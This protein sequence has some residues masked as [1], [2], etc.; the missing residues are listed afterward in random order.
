MKVLTRLKPAPAPA[1][2]CSVCGFETARDALRAALWVCPACGVHLAM[3]AH[4]RVAS[5]VDPRSFRE[6]DRRMIS[7]DPLRFADLHAYRARL[8]DARKRT[9]LREA[10]VVGQARVGGLPVV[11]AVFEF[12][13]LGGSM[14]SVVGEKIADAFEVATRR[15]WPVI[16]V[17]SS[18][19]AR[20][21]EGM[22]SLMQMAKTAA[23]RARHHAAG[24]AYISVLA[25]PTFGGVA[26]SFASLGD[27][28]IA[29]PG[30]R[31]G[32]AGPR[33]IEATVG[34][35]LPADSH[36]A[37]R[38]FEGGMV[39]LLLE[40]RA[41]RETVQFL[42]R[43]LGRP[44]GRPWV[45]PAL[46][47]RLQ[48]DTSPAAW[49][50]VQ[51]ARHPRRPRSSDYIGR[52]VSSFVELHG[53]RQ[54]GDDPSVIGGLGEIDGH[55]IV[56]VGLEKNQVPGIS[57]GH[58]GMA[59]PEGYREA[60]RLMQLAAKFHLPLLT[61]IDTP[62]AYPGY[63]AERRGIAQALAQN[64]Q[65]MALLPTP[66]VSVVIGEGGSGGALA[67]GVADRVLMQEHAFYSVI[68]PEAAAAILYRDASRA[69]D[70]AAALM[71][72][73]ADLLRLGVIDGII[74][75][76]PGGAH[77]DPDAAAAEVRR[78]VVAAMADLSRQS[79]KRLVAHRYDKY[80]H[81]GRVGGPW[82]DAIRE[83]QNVLDM[84]EGRLH[85]RGAGAAS[86]PSPTQ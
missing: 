41:L 1:V 25:H 12:E 22:L 50:V 86:D 79:P 5:L 3:P 71:L 49:D 54:F 56:I 69:A 21:Q 44:T 55:T 43:H 36:Q 80:R 77:A 23:A 10:V 58:E 67:L 45:S 31:I 76:P 75:E 37:E 6:F 38:L 62:G 8:L 13:F 18:G 16:T 26:A 28:L 60:L 9:G 40:R 84:V 4:E 19:G 46:P 24:L 33:V 64:L 11:L 59:F 73:A 48:E 51:K 20:M 78:H 2:R 72:T 65:A 17:T 29:E 53:D 85:R 61:F 42:V 57:A 39:D 34:E 81:M 47:R 30:A 83:V 52:I 32:F 82:R 74:P 35:T 66:I 15:H 70:M 68:S 27:V 14:G 7:V 63:D